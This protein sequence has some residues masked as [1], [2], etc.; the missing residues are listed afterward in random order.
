MKKIAV[1]IFLILFVSA[2]GLFLFKYTSLKKLVNING[3]S[4]VTPKPLPP[5]FAQL[6]KWVPAATWG[7]PEKSIEMTPYGKTSGLKMTGE[8]RGKNPSITRN[9]EDIKMM[10]T[11]GYFEDMQFAA[12][13]P[14]SSNWGYSKTENG[15]TQIVVFRYS[16]NAILGPES[17]E[18]PFV[19]LSVYISDPFVIEQ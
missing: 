12:D 15:K 11:L 19:N 6:S 1:I 2:A 16:T 13:G 14:G 5:I 3:T 17:K 9:F 8:I 10:E 4:R 7:T 18:P